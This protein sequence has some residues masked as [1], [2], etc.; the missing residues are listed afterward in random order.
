MLAAANG[1]MEVCLKL[2][3]LGADL[4]KANN[5]SETCCNCMSVWLLYHLSRSPSSLNKGGRTALMWAAEK[6][7][8]EVCVKLAE[9]GADLSKTDRVSETCFN[10]ISVHCC[11]IIM[12]TLCL[13]IVGRQ[14][15]FA[16]GC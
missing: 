9:L 10:C 7:Q 1:Q 8:M 13:E 4:N 2:A 11:M 6:G 3:E 15:G 16:V 12:L 14:D 5:V